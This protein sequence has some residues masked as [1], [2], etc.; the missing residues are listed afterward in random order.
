MKILV[1]GAGGLVGTEL[2]RELKA[3]GHSIT[4]LSTSQPSSPETIR[5]DPTRG[6][7]DASRLEGFDAVVHLAGESIVGSNPVTERWTEA[8]K[9][10][11]M[12]SRRDGTTLLANTLAGLSD[13]PEVLVSASAV[14]YYGSR[15]NELLTE[16]S[17]PGDDF[18]AGV[19][20]VWELSAD[21]AR[22]AGIRVVHPRIGIVLSKNGGALASTLP[23][24]KLGLGGKVG[25][26]KQFWSWVALTDL[27]GSIHH[28]I[29][30][31]SVEGPVNIGSPNPMTNAE[32]TEVLGD[33]LGRPTLLPLPAPVARVVLGEVADALLLSSARMQ[34]RALENTGYTFR[35]PELRGALRSIL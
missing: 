23:I 17:A 6:Q 18:L 33:V 13:K 16:E 30:N 27:A 9:A 26:G 1:S 29:E 7:V 35:H 24:F 11:I 15:G 14:G 21:A 10:K 22:N 4:A 2:T 12:N 34:P 5:W 8:K 3:A 31:D 25:D 28:A 32:Y 20:R 19:C